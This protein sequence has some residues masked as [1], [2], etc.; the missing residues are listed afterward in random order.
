MIVRAAP[1]VVM[2]VALLVAKLA[3]EKD[4]RPVEEREWTSVVYKEQW[5]VLGRAVLWGKMKEGL[6]AFLLVGK[7]GIQ[8]EVLRKVEWMVDYVVVGWGISQGVV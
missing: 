8:Y 3:V 4:F 6:K 7:M 5:W 1:T 2:R